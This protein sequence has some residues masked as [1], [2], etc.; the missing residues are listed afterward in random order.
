MSSV[1]TFAWVR[2]YVR[3]EHDQLNWLMPPCESVERGSKAGMI[4]KAR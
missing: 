3:G 4:T 1:L 2:T